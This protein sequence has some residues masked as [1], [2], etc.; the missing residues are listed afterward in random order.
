MSDAEDGR[1]WVCEQL[2]R[3]VLNNTD[4]EHLI[5]KANVD[6]LT[7]ELVGGLAAYW[8]DKEP[9]VQDPTGLRYY[10]SDMTIHQTPGLD[11]ETDADGSVVAVWF[12]CQPLPFKQS[13]ANASRAMN[14][15]RMYS[16]NPSDAPTIEAVVLKETT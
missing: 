12:R 8:M 15:R 7:K 13:H 11:V 2:V 10:G 14:M 9:E 6:Q 1:K 4:V 3:D 16:D 5:T